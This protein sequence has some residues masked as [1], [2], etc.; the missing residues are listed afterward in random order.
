MTV[1]KPRRYTYTGRCEAGHDV[2]NRYDL[3]SPLPT[4]ITASCPEMIPF[5]PD[6]PGVLLLPGVE[7]PEVVA[8]G[9]QVSLTR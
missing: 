7:A 1:T 2:E 3:T 8:C 4:E 6:T 5:D 9:L